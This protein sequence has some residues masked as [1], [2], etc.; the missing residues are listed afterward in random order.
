MSEY[1][2]V[3]RLEQLLADTIQRC[4][5]II[6]QRNCTIQP[7][8]NDDNSNRNK[9][10]NEYISDSSISIVSLWKHNPNLPL[11]IDIYISSNH[12]DVVLLIERWTIHFHMIDEISEIRKSSIN[13]KVVTFIRSLQCFTRLLPGF[14]LLNYSTSIPNL[15]FDIY[16]NTAQKC[17]NEFSVET[18]AYQLPQIITAKGSLSVS[19]QYTQ[20]NII[21]SFLQLPHI[22]SNW[23][24]PNITRS[25]LTHSARTSI[26][27]TL[28]LSPSKPI[29]ISSNE[30]QR[31]RSESIG[32]NS[33]PISNPFL[34]GGYSPMDKR[35]LGKHIS[36]TSPI[37]SSPFS[38]PPK[39]SFITNFKQSSPSSRRESSSPMPPFTLQDYNT[40]SVSGIA[41]SYGSVPPSFPLRN[42]N[43][44]STSPQNNTNSSWTLRE[45]NR[46]EKEATEDC[47]VQILQQLQ[48]FELKRIPKKSPFDKD[49]D[50]SDKDNFKD[51]LFDI[52]DFEDN[53]SQDE[54]LP[55]ALMN[56][57]A[58]SIAFNPSTQ[59]ITQICI[60]SLITFND[61][62][63]YSNGKV[64]QKAIIS[65]LTEYKE[66]KKY[67]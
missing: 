22:T 57:N 55:F 29:P 67:I 10:S 33:S 36:K 59:P 11:I 46:H 27:P 13:R 56:P 28:I 6:L 66:L 7:M 63:E 23:S 62:I 25:K 39:Q 16:N 12:S 2:N 53:S 51:T 32:S 1:Q 44:T 14:L 41:L 19:V 64:L 20:A 17:I 9:K 50:S 21:Q 49:T 37:G 31:E 43:L 35:L 40:A 4:S 38:T 34:S 65:T 8:Y 5:T 58:N 24:L 60:D 48:E 30:S 15:Y 18:S 47:K 52:E 61:S 3:L 45:N 42:T 26:D 54:S